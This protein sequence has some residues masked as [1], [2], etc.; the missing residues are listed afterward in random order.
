M[1]NTGQ[2]WNAIPVR[3]SAAGLVKVP[4]VKVPRF[5]IG[6]LVSY[7]AVGRSYV[8]ECGAGHLRL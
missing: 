6:D 3:T 1:L 2:L 7:L 5:R 4:G 8:C